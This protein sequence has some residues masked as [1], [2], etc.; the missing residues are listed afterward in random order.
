MS[1]ALFFA[2]TKCVDA[3]KTAWLQCNGVYLQRASLS[4]TLAP[5]TEEQFANLMQYLLDPGET[6]VKE[7]LPIVITTDNK[8]RWHETEGMVHWN[9]F[10]FAGEVPRW[11][12]S[13][14]DDDDNDE[15][16]H[17]HDWP[18]EELEEII[19]ELE[20]QQDGDQRTDETRLMEAKEAMRTSIT[21]TSPYWHRVEALM[22]QGSLEDAEEDKMQADP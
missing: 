22:S 19:I 9:I 3:D 6:D 20:N 17:P 21:P 8:W 10:K 5:P 2:S 16:Y 14:T 13:S 7:P 1:P 11:L 4:A 12:P 15:L 18:E